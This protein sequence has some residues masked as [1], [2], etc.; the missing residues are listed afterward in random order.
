VPLDGFGFGDDQ[1][2]F[3]IL[4]IARPERICYMP[5]DIGART[6]LTVLETVSSVISVACH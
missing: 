2:L 5:Q 4:S 1:F 6:A 3:V